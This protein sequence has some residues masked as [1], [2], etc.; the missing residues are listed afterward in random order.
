MS[1][2]K[3]WSNLPAKTEEGNKPA[4]MVRC[5]TVHYIKMNGRE[6]IIKLENVNKPS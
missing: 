6:H 2:T 4:L 1:S 5:I 3:P